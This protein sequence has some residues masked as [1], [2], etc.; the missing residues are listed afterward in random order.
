MP[1]PVCYTG[2][3]SRAPCTTQTHNRMTGE[4]ESNM[5]LN[6]L[7]MRGAVKRFLK[8][9]PDY[10]MERLERIYA[11]HPPVHGVRVGGG[12]MI[13]EAPLGGWILLVKD[14]IWAYAQRTDIKVNYIP[15]GHQ[16]NVEIWIR[17]SEKFIIPTMTEQKAREVLLYLYPL[18]TGAVFGHSRELVKVW[19]SGMKDGHAQFD[20]LAAA[21]H[22]A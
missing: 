17:A 6:S 9:H 4:M 13:V 1:A 21:Q 18:L 12:V 16:T 8:E 7:K 3:V 14:I 22:Q 5:A 20:L 11:A 19:N 2:I 15:M 10:T